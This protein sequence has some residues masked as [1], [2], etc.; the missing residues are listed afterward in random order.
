[1]R[2]LVHEKVCFWCM[3]WL[4]HRDEQVR[5]VYGVNN[6]LKLVNFEFNRFFKIY[7]A[8]IAI[9]V[10][11]QITGMIVMSRNYMSHANQAMYEEGLSQTIFI[12]QYGSMSFYRVAQTIWV[13]GPI[14]LCIVALLF[15][16]FLIWYRD[17]FGKNTFIYRLLM[18]PTERINVFFA[19]ATTIF[20]M[21][22]GL[23]ALQIFLL[24][25]D[26]AIMKWL[27]PLDFR[28][29]LSVNE[30][31]SAFQYLTIIFP[32]NFFDFGVH[33][34]IG[35]MSVFVL[36]TA[37][38]FE[39]S[40]GIKGIILGIIYCAL[41]LL[42]IISPGILTVIY[43]KPLLYPREYFVLEVIL[44]SIVVATSIIVSRFL[45]NNRVTV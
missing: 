6:Y 32:Y 13:M 34:A 10:I 37:I 14:T 19:K 16:V 29:D 5:G 7:A 9:T 40:F 38:L 12:E 20:L 2:W 22:L 8:L 28:T 42:L 1:M 18:L 24:P 30:M 26:S 4:I 35:F 41:T 25:I 33:Y 39:R 3:M 15:Y 27:V 45:L 21:V 23:V 17:W 43:E 31:I 11:S 44:C 36:F